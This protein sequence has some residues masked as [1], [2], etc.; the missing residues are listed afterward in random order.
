MQHV[1]K[2][3]RAGARKAALEDEPCQYL[4][5][6]TLESKADRE[7]LVGLRLASIALW[8]SAS[9][10]P[11]EY[12]S[13]LVSL[14]DGWCPGELGDINHGASFVTRFRRSCMKTL[15][16]FQF[17]DV[18]GR[19]TAL[20]VPSDYC[21]VSDGITCGNG[22]PLHVHLHVQEGR[23]G[24]LQYHL[25]GL[26]PTTTLPEN[27]NTRHLVAGLRF[28]TA[29]GIVHQGRAAEEAF[30]ITKRMAR[31]RF[32]GRV[33]D[34]HEEGP[35]GIQVA[36]HHADILGLKASTAWGALDGWH[37]SETAGAQADA[38][39]E[40]LI[41]S[42]LAS[43]R[44]LRSRFSFGAQSA[45]PAAVSLLVW[46]SAASLF[47]SFPAA[48]DM[49]AMLVGTEQ[50][51]LFVKHSFWSGYVEHKGIGRELFF[52]FR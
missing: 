35:M 33:G 51:R 49:Q 39:S 37:A 20:K 28:S 29:E 52:G 34:G 1:L 4:G 7:V 26:E 36:K 15:E 43:A 40:P 50:I 17:W 10:L 24:R 23:H 2:A 13:E 3:W 31:A 21:I 18:H 8:L 42:Y 5:L 48:I 46:S 27:S 11:S 9:G 25:L 32:A 45:I 12:Y 22:T 14:W 44:S 41:S 38:G 30:G 47:F 6:R 16:K 19:L